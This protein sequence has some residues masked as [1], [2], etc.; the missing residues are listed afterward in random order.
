M[1]IYPGL[2]PSLINLASPDI[3]TDLGEIRTG[4][5]QIVLK[6][7]EKVRKFKAAQSAV[8]NFH[9]ILNICF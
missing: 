7:L 6:I 9:T 5:V 2:V 1:I 3:S 4:I 8:L